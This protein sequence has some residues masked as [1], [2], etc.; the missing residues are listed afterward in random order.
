MKSPN[1]QG[2]LLHSQSEVGDLLVNVFPSN[3]EQ[4]FGAPPL[5]ASKN[6]RRHSRQC[7]VRAVK[8]IV[9]TAEEICIKFLPVS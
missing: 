8:F 9:N 6:F 1:V 5:S 3:R 2:S 4:A 7:I